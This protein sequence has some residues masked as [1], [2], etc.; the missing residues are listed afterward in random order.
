MTRNLTCFIYYIYSFVHVYSSSSD[1]DSSIDSDMDEE[2]KNKKEIDKLIKQADKEFGMF[3]WDFDVID[4]L[5][6]FMMFVI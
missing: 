1:S 5:I 6:K 3:Y 4:L 2:T